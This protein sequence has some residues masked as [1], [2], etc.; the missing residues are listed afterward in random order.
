MAAPA[1]LLHH[2]S[3]LEHDMG[4]HPEQPDRITAIER[5]LSAR[6][7]LGFERIESEPAPRAVLERVHPPGYVDA[8]E[9]FAAAGGGPIDP[10]TSMSAGS[11]RAALHAAG[12]AVGLVEAWLD[13]RARAGLSLHRPPGHHA[14]ADRAMGF[15]FLNNVAVAARHAPESLRCPRVLIFDWDVHHGNGT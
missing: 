3:S 12:G 1:V 10:D 15:C 5:E 14:T 9:R 7:W 6:A 2:P 4:A 13:G 8:L 11:F